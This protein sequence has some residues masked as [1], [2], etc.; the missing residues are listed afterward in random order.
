MNT[1]HAEVDRVVSY[2]MVESLPNNILL[3]HSELL[4]DV[5]LPR[6][7]LLPLSLNCLYFR[8]YRR[9][10]LVFIDMT[11]VLLYSIKL[12]VMIL[13]RGRLKL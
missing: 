9:Y 10:E 3:V 8:S 4:N 6:F 13:P 5:C 7:T 2:L 11:I 12:G 1:V